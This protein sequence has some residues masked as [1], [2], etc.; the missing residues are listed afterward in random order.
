[1]KKKLTNH[2][3]NGDKKTNYF[4]DILYIIFFILEIFKD[5]RATQNVSLF[6]NFNEY[7]NLE[8]NKNFFLR[9]APSRILCEFFLFNW[10]KNNYDPN[11]KINI[12]DVGCG[13]GVALKIFRKFFKEFNYFGCDYRE[14]ENWKKLKKDGI[15]LFKYEIGE[16]FIEDLPNIDLVHSQSVFEH[17]KYDL[18]GFEILSKKF[19]KAKHIH[20]LPAPLS[21][22][23]YE[24]HGYRR[25]AFKDLIKLKKILNKDKL[26]I[27]NI[28][29][30]N[31]FKYHFNFLINNNFKKFK[32]SKFFQHNQDFDD[33]YKLINFLIFDK[34]RSFPVFYAL[35]F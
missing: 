22:L 11:K 17:V 24:K 7:Y 19:E 8:N 27:Y 32:M 13:N 6:E 14:R 29:G 35:E 34:L 18:S 9:T 33:S 12:L 25:Y 20:F 15:T 16:N 4:E 23:N 3:I 2:F 30:K 10:L 28:G 1:M 26:N 21:F 31:T 5:K